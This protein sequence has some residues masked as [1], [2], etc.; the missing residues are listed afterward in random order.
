MES[1]SQAL[2]A[3]IKELKQRKKITYSDIMEAL[4]K[5]NGIPVLSFATVRRVFAKGSESRAS[6]FS[7][8]TTLV[9]I[10]E[11]IKRIDGSIDNLPQSEII[12]LLK[13]QINEKDDIIQRLIDR[14]DQKDAIIQQFLSDMRQKDDTINCLM[15]K[16]L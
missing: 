16:C 5:E 11:A 8:E 13:D 6:S 2:I 4:P 3:Q 12:L 9:P 14:L 7:Y 15:N 1:K 10:S